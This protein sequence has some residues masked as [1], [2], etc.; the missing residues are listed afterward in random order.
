MFLLVHASAG[1]GTRTRTG[2]TSRGILNPK[3]DAK[4]PVLEANSQESAAHMQ[5]AGLFPPD[6]A[7]VIDAWPE[8][9]ENVRAAILALISTE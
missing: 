4:N 5:R 7:T 9:P 8:L 3:Q 6:L 1:G 2:V